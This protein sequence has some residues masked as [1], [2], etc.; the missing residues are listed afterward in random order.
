MAMVSRI[1]KAR[2]LKALMRCYIHEIPRYFG[3]KEIAIM[4]HDEESG[5]LYTITQGDDDDARVQYEKMR[6]LAKNED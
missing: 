5:Q 2:T 4:F 6:K 3:F 1:V